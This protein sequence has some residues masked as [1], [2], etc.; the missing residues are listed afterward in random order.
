M[1]KVTTSGHDS[2]SEVLLLHGPVMTDKH[3]QLFQ[4]CVCQ[5]CLVR[6]S[7]MSQSLNPLKGDYIGEYHMSSRIY[8][9][10]RAEEGPRWYFPVRPAFLWE[11][12]R[13]HGSNE[14]GR[15]YITLY[16]KV[17]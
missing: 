7:D 13:A 6:F 10:K 1:D 16:W 15:M 14:I 11:L 5:S 17:S 12:D 9:R 3:D 2:G 4:S 8:L